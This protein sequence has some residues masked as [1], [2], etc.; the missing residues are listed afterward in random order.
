M[1]LTGKYLNTD[2][3]TTLE[4]SFNNFETALINKGYYSNRLYT[5]K[6]VE[7]LT[8]PYQIKNIFNEVENF[9]EDIDYTIIDWINPYGMYY[10]TKH[11]WKRKNGLLFPLVNRWFNWIDYNFKII[12]KEIPKEQFLF[13]NLS[14]MIYDINGDT[15]LTQEGY[16]GEE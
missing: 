7:R 15:I 11:E 6:Y 10:M 9:I 1:G 2:N 5:P 16:F 8:L 14:E 13:D 3:F 4:S 12:N